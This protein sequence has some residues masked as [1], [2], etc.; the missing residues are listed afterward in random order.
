MD[1]VI[2]HLEFCPPTAAVNWASSVLQMFP[3]R[4]GIMT[5]HGYLGL[6]AQRS[7]HSCT[8]TQYLWDLLAPPNPNLHFMLSG[9][10]HGESRRVDTVNGHAVH[11]MLADYQDRATGGE[12]WLRILRFVPADDK[13]YVQTYSPW[14]N[15]FEADADSEFTLDFPMGGV[16]TNAGSVSA[17]SGSTAS[18]ATAGLL[19]ST[20][21]EWRMSVTNAAGK[22]QTGPVWTFTTGTDGTINQ[23]PTANGQLVNVL[24]DA[25][26]TPITLAAADPEGGP[27]TYTI[28]AGPSHGA[29]DG[30]APAVTYQPVANFT[31]ADSFTF[32]ANDGQ[33]NSNVAAVSITIQAV[34]DPPS[35]TGESYTAQSGSM[36]TAAAP[37]VLANDSDIDSA[38][39]T[40]VLVS[41]P[42]HGALTL[43][44]NG[45]FTYTPAAGYS[46]P[47]AFSYV[48]NDGE[49]DSGVATA[50]VTV[51]AAPLPT[52]SLA[53]APASIVQGATATLSWTTQNA[54]SLLIDQGVGAVTPVTGGSRPVSPTVTTTYTGAVTG[55][56]GSG[57]CSTTLTVTPPSPG[58]TGLIAAYEFAAGSG[59]AIVD[60]SG[61]NLNGTATSTAWTTAGRYG[62]ALSFNGSSSYVNLGNPLALQATGSM[63]WTAW[64][65]ATSTPADDGQIIAKSGGTSGWQFKTSPDTGPH[66]FG[67]MISGSTGVVQRYSTTIRALNTWYHVA[68]VYNAPARTLDIYVNG[69]LDNGALI[70]TIPAAQTVPTTNV[71]IGRRSGGFYFGGI[72][73]DIRIYG[74]PLTADEIRTVMTTPIP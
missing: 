74:R 7:V 67:I 66:T 4:I 31:G 30:S 38:T 36:L 54:T 71:N 3:D 22:T 56:G 26:A 72:L 58:P 14:L 37:G 55:T 13:V 10:V 52:C 73:D 9:H 69:V 46:G 2:A 59:T 47:D 42:S 57:N 29:L 21:Y 1:F 28:V 25:P 17:P 12:G 20:L 70:G 35:A 44:T 61:N 32:M 39:M 24:E 50:T 64:V 45:S 63:S 19:P 16:F 53:A 43:N 41:N 60:S 27:L 49:A 48:A 5:T 18:I 33:A 8:N 34:N 62:N 23:P 51:L 6:S 68:A 65:R 15:R 40:A 11:Q